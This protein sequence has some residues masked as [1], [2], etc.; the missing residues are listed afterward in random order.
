MRVTPTGLIG[1]ARRSST[2]RVGL[3]GLAKA[4]ARIDE[5][6]G[7][8]ELAT[9]SRKQEVPVRLVTRKAE[10]R[11]IRLT[12]KAGL[13][14]IRLTRKAMLRKIWL[15]QK[16]RLCRTQGGGVGN[17]KKKK[18]LLQAKG[19]LHGGAQ[20]VLPRHKNADCK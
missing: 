4:V 15:T 13:H 2:T 3:A 9:Q 14:R 10:L 11:K 18:V 17:Q 6:I 12:R 5:Q 8:V 19:Q 20:G 1:L 16:T 7:F